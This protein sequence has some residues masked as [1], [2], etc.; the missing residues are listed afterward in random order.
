MCDSF[1]SNANR[2]FIELDLIFSRLDFNRK[3]AATPE[4]REKITTKFK[5]CNNI[6]KAGD[7]DVLTGK[8][9]TT[10]CL[11]CEN[12]YTKKFAFISVSDYLNNVY[13]NLAMLNY[14]YN[15]S[16]LAT[17]PANPVTE[18]CSHINGSYNDD[19]LFDVCMKPI[20]YF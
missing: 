17:L 8:F 1:L 3:L 9:F 13:Q 7:M 15:T 19:Q 2:Y 5:L 4:G 11:Y 16:F 18:F 10:L 6:T 12:I 14:P 20:F